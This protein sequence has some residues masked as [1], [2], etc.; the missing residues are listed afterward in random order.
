MLAARDLLDAWERG[1]A[2]PIPDRAPS[3]LALLDPSCAVDELSVGQSDALLYGLRTR[4]FGPALDA[5]APCPSCAE[6]VSI[7]LSLDDV[8]PELAEPPASITSEHGGYRLTV[9]S[10]RNH[11]LSALSGLGAS[12]QVADVVGRCLVEAFDPSGSAVAVVDVPDEVLG[13]VLADLAEADPAANIILAIKCVCGASW[14]DQLDIRAVLWAD[15][16]EWA[17]QLLACVH[18]LAR[19]YGWSEASILGL[20]PRRREWYRQALEW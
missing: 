4:L 20:S 1:D 12:V 18:D 14:T 19:G 6:T 9:R 10:P 8:A 7:T 11:D 5:S 16:D 2:L 13:A 15:L 17:T 3:L